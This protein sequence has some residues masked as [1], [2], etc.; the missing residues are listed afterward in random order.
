MTRFGRWIVEGESV[1]LDAAG[2]AIT[3][4]LEDLITPARVCAFA[5]AYRELLTAVDVID[6]HVAANE[7]V[8]NAF[9]FSGVGSTAA[10]CGEPALAV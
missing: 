5:W 4:E 2:F 6:L 3:A 8:W 10:V 7:L 9:D 1:R